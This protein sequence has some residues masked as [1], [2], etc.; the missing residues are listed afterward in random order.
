MSSQKY[1]HTNFLIISYSETEI[2]LK[3]TDERNRHPM[4]QVKV[5]LFTKPRVNPP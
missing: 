1:I 3:Y 5:K 2:K 4:A